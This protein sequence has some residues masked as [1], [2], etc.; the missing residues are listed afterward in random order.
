MALLA[1]IAVVQHHA[2]HVIILMLL[3]QPN[4]DVIMC[5]N[6]FPESPANFVLSSGCG[7]LGD[8]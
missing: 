4:Q 7:V 1:L 5:A 6:F 2:W 3:Y 8:R